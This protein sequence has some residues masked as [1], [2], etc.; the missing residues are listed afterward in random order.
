MQKGIRPPPSLG[1]I[2]KELAADLGE[3][4]KE[5]E[6][7][8]LIRWS[9]QGVL[10]LNAVLT[11]QTKNPNSH[12]GKGWEQFTDAVIRIINAKLKGVVFILWGAYA[13]KKASLVTASKHHVLA[14]A[15]PS[16]FSATKFFG[17]R[18]FSKT[19]AFLVADG[20]TPIDWN[21]D[22]PLPA[23][24]ASTEAEPT[25]PQN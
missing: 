16:P 10:L 13:Q 4:W 3:S 20:K 23:A 21:V 25:P 22:G 15:H 24:A 14:S 6:H 1:N 2:Y 9:R 11:V 12:Q 18:H 17:C 8:H 5:P 7:G 19:N